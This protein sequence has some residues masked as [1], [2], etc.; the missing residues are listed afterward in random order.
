M[1]GVTR[2]IEA[3]PIDGT[4]VK[5]MFWSIISDYDLKTGLCE[6][7]DNALDLWKSNKQKTPLKIEVTLD[8]QRQLI[9]ITDNAGGVKKDELDLLII[10]GGSR[11]NPGAHVIGIFGVGSKRA[12]IA[13]GELVRI[14]TRFK[15][16][17][18][19][20]I[21]IGKAWLETNDWNLAY[22][23]IPDIKP[24][25]TYIEISHLR[26]P[27]IPKDV[28]NI[29]AHFGE[30]YDWFLRQGCVIEVNGTEI[31]PHAFD[32]WAYPPGYNPKA[33]Q[34]DAELAPGGGDNCTN[35]RRSDPR[36]RSRRRQLWSLFL[37]QRTTNC[38]GASPTRGG[39]LRKLASRS[40]SS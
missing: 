32:T 11:N 18:S 16:E 13:L 7:V 17:Q 2:K 34:F 26:K 4:P 35:N 14:Q 15:K 30:T 31:Q 8:V 24:N 3:G 22:Y 10:P 5:R 20:E 39:V 1:T 29:S 19:F 12:G 25:S 38:E 21:E 28:E 36:P 37:L 9:S 27:L 33:A 23:E 40:T 6:L